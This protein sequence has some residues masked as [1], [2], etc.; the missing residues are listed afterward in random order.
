MLK[1]NLWLIISIVGLSFACNKKFTQLPSFSDGGSAE[2]EPVALNSCSL[3]ASPKELPASGGNVSLRLTVNSTKAVKSSSIDSEDLNST[4][5]GSLVRN[6]T[7]D[8]DY[9][10]E[11]NFEDGTSVNCD[12]QVVVSSSLLSPL[13]ENGICKGMP[14]DKDQTYL[15][16]L[17]ENLKTDNEQVI[18]KDLETAAS[19]NDLLTPEKIT[20]SS[21]YQKDS[22]LGEVLA[23]RNSA[24][25]DL[26]ALID[27]STTN[28]NECKYISHTKIENDNVAYVQFETG[29]ETAFYVSMLQD[30]SYSYSNTSYYLAKS[31]SVT[32]S[33]P[34]QQSVSIIANTALSQ[35]AESVDTIKLEYCKCSHTSYMNNAAS[36]ISLGAAKSLIAPTRKSFWISLPKDVIWR[37]S[38]EV[39]R[40]QSNV[41][42]VV[43]EQIM[44][45]PPEDAKPDECPPIVA[46]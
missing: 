42:S 26:C 18:Q 14:T 44:V 41:K 38:P 27:L 1:L 16:Q 29:Q 25:N 3:T 45:E 39:I 22:L 28:Q 46:T 7:A 43:F 35:G 17:N 40:V 31:L 20:E 4:A 37:L 13:V 2:P 8:K 30:F 11:V 36:D 23:G 9:S 6:T 24:S 5:G 15:D 21:S 19:S 34:P 12:I 10:A 32:D 33:F